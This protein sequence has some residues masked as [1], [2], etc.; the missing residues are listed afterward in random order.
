MKILALA[1]A[2]ATTFHFASPV[3]AQSCDME[4]QSSCCNYGKNAKPWKGYQKGVQW[5]K[6]LDAAMQRAKKE[7]K[8]ILVHQLVG[9]MSKD[10]C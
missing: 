4:I 9:D 10:G 1:V 2:V 7:G 5:E 3:E 8:P 6:S